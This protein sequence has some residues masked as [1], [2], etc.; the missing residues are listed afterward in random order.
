MAREGSVGLKKE[1][2]RTIEKQKFHKRKST[3]RTERFRSRRDRQRR[4]RDSTTQEEELK[5]RRREIRK[6]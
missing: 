2:E 3:R 4:R 1:G 5:K 6:S